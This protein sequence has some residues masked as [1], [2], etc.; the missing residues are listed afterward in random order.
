MLKDLEKKWIKDRGM[1]KIIIMDKNINLN[2]RYSNDN[3]KKQN[4]NEN[5]N[6]DININAN[7]KYDT[8][9]WKSHQKSE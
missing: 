3:S 1:D 7:N 4:K 6:K 8:N 9:I 5:M 2:Y